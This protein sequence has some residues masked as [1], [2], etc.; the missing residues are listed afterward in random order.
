MSV[1]DGGAV[2]IVEEAFVSVVRVSVEVWGG[3]LSRKGIAE[4]G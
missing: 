4:R 1:K 3:T 2:A